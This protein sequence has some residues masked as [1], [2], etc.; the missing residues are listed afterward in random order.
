MKFI[1]DI[2]EILAG[3]LETKTPQQK[4]NEQITSDEVKVLLNSTLGIGGT[5]DYKKSDQT[6]KLVD[7]DVLKVFLKNNP[8]SKREYVP[9]SHDCDDFHFILMGDVTRWDSD[10]AFGI[11]WGWKPGGAYHAWNW[12]VGTDRNIWFVEPQNDKVFAPAEFWK[13]NW[14]TM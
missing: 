7:I 8:V 11:I 5:A 12:C 3:I 4:S 14:L 2:L 6:Y 1:T 9:I 10:L 13:T